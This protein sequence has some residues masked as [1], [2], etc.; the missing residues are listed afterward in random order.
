MRKLQTGFLHQGDWV[1]NYLKNLIINT[2]EDM[3]SCL[4]RIWNPPIFT[5]TQKS[6]NLIQFGYFSKTQSHQCDWKSNYLKKVITNTLENM[7]SFL[8]RFRNPQKVS[9]TQGLKSQH[10][11][12]NPW[13]LKHNSIWVS[14]IFNLFS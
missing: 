8:S 3:Q 13:T 7:Q 11:L 6:W 14:L 5:K 12:T 2:L 10:F 4:S 9:K 1:P